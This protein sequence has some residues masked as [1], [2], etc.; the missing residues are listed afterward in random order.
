MSVEIPDIESLTLD[1]LLELRARTSA[2]KPYLLFGDRRWTYAELQHSVE[3]LAGGLAQAG[4]GAD[5]HV[6]VHLSNRPEFVVLF[7][8]VARIGA[9][10]V[11]TNTALKPDELGYIL[12]HAD[13]SFMVTEARH[14][15]CVLA[16]MAACPALRTIVVL[17]QPEGP[18]PNGVRRI[19]WNAL[20]AAGAY[21]PPNPAAADSTSLIMYTSG[22]TSL[23]KGVMIAHRSVLA[24]GHAWMWLA[25]FTPKDRTMS[26]FPL[27]HA[28]ALFF[29]CVGSMVWGGSYVLLPEFRP[30]RYLEFARQYDVTHFNFAG[31]AMGIMLQQP[32]DRSDSDHRVRV[33]HNAM[34][35]SGLIADWSR[36][37][38]IAVVMIYN[39]TECALATGTP[40][41]GP[42]AVKVGS[43]GWPAP[44]LPSPT[45]VRLVDEDG[46][47]V[48]DS[49]IGEI[50]LRGPGLMTGYYKDPPRTAEAIRGGWLH[51][52]D[53]A[54]RDADGCYWY[55]DRLKDM[56]K[57]GGEN[58][59]SAEVEG[60]LAAHPAIAEAGVFGVEDPVYGE[61]IKAS[62]RLRPEIDPG[63]VPPAALVAWCRE[64]L[65]P[66]KVP[67]FIEYREAP[68]PRGVGGAKILKRELRR[69]KAD[70]IAGCFDARLGQIAGTRLALPPGADRPGCAIRRPRVD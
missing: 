4:V 15:D 20:S 10:L 44:S 58:V 32:P 36:R 40:V 43:I 28:N 35:S 5:T 6:G 29:S 9:V 16:G 38:D 24:A 23:P 8:A 33:V 47:D 70:P 67:R 18:A 31:P 2:D 57:P 17:D 14:A 66:F 53:A 27:F 49:E 46:R 3:A 45:E 26:G 25:G 34:G 59:S 56:I 42:R 1:R 65:A 11:P 48:G 64:R 50:L 30:T 13:V 37:F 68:L 62:V 55:A 52:G 63:S 21:L 69:E 12:N 41:S 61:Q 54:Y 60:V 51:T 19:E 39:L 7:L 22:T